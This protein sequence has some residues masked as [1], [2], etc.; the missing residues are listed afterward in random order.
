[1][2]SNL[3]SDSYCLMCLKRDTIRNQQTTVTAVLRKIEPAAREKPFHI[4]TMPRGL[5]P[6]ALQLI[7]DPR[8]RSV[9]ALAASA[10]CLVSAAARQASR[11]CACSCS[12]DAEADVP[13]TVSFLPHAA[14]LGQVLHAP[15]HR[16]TCWV[17]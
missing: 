8:V 5:T 3:S 17:P 15:S 4:F 9:T 6:S 11:L 10:T 12:N 14:D 16:G 2:L 1:M 13:A 7:R